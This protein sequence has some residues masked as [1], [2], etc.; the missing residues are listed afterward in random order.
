MEWRETTLRIP[1]VSSM[2]DE[3]IEAAFPDRDGRWSSSIK[4]AIR[5]H[6]ASDVDLNQA[7]AD[8]PQTWVCPCCERPK[9]QLLRL[10]RA[11][12][13]LAHLHEHHDHLHER[14]ARRL[15][16]TFGAHWTEGITLGT[17]HLE[18][19]GSQIIERLEPVLVCADCNIA[20]AAVKSRLS[21]IDPDFSFRC[22]EIRT[23]ISPAPNCDHV[24]DFNL[25]GSLW[26]AARDEFVDRCRLADMLAERMEQGH[27]VRER[28][29]SHLNYQALQDGPAQVQ[30]RW[31]DPEF[32]KAIQDDA[33]ALRLRSISRGAVGTGR[34][35][36]RRP[37][38]APVKDVVARYDGGAFPALWAQLTDDWACPGCRRSRRSILRRSRSPRRNWS[39]HVQLH[40]E[41]HIAEVTGGLRVTHHTNHLIC[42][43]CA[44]IGAR[45][46]QADPTLEPF[47]LQLDQIARSVEVE[48][49]RKHELRVDG[50]QRAIA[51]AQDLWPA[52]AAYDAGLQVATS[53]RSSFRYFLAA[54]NGNNAEAWRKTVAQLRRGSRGETGAE[55]SVRVR[56]LIQ[57]PDRLEPDGPPVRFRNPA[58]D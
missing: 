50:L 52:Y 49:N 32:L 38:V 47:K 4:A 9:P 55:A 45:A 24:V 35:S 27:F 48:D 16:R 25:A 1:L 6:A 39:G 11:Q 20:D 13:L 12:V 41:Y 36:R 43:G 26:N 54:T 2:T 28:G 44:G 8:T 17:Y 3:E 42:D 21:D 5:R 18:H 40:R 56:E 14:I 37:A 23:F 10:N 33:L 30:S 19:L 29:R 34:A 57:T 51:E 7:W 15:Q 46:V 53:A 58:K 22:S 31:A